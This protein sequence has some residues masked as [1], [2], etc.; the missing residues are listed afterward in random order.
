MKLKVI[1]ALSALFAMSTFAQAQQ[2]PP[3]NVPKPTKADVQKVVQIIS[4]DKAK[5]QA[6]CEMGKLNEQMAE[7]DQKKD[8][9]TLDALG[10]Q[11]DALAEKIGPEYI[12]LMEGLDQVDE[13]S[14]L[15]KQL[16]SLFAPLDK[17]CGN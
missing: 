15:G 4:A 10:K 9:K 1:I 7:A 16:E 2:G 11:S 17:L 8:Q 3:P 14:P 12:R 13:N 6:Y 5:T